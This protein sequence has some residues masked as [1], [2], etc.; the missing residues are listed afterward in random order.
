MLGKEKEPEKEIAHYVADSKLRTMHF[1]DGMFKDRGYDLSTKRV[2]F[3]EKNNLW[4][5]FIRDHKGRQVL[6]ILT[7][8]CENFGD[9]LNIANVVM[10]MGSEDK[11]EDQVFPIFEGVSS[12]AN[13]QKNQKTG[14]DFI[15]SLIA[16]CEDHK[17][18]KN[19]ILIT[20]D[21]TP[22]AIK[23]ISGSTVDI[24]CFTYME[25]CIRNT[26]R[27]F[28]QPVGFR[29]LEKQELKHYKRLNPN[30]SKFLQRYS[31]EDPLVKYFGMNVGDIICYEDSDRHTALVSEYGLIV[32]DL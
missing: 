16:H 31:N 11:T 13:S 18:L 28:N 32:E 27:H 20:D 23:V 19:V 10:D 15:K 21:I 1:L 29:R 22:H 3:L 5:I 12:G 9:S 4:E 25:T 30:Y 6:S 8:V 26:S 2:I 7:P 24:V 14:T 17:E